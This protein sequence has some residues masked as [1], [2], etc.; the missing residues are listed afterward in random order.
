LSSHGPVFD[1]RIAHLKAHCFEKGVRHPAADEQAVAFC[2]QALDDADLVRDLGPA[3]DGDV[4][5]L[6]ALGCLPQELEFLLHQKPG[7]GRQIVRHSLGRG[8]GAVGRAKS[9]VDENGG[10]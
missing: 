1:Q 2:Q 3:Q 7:H 4:G 9:V 10:Q 8:V 6:G 5:V